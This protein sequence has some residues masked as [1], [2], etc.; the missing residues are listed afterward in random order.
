MIHNW[1]VRHRVP[2]NGLRGGVMLNGGAQR[3]RSDNAYTYAGQAEGMAREKELD[4]TDRNMDLSHRRLC[5]PVDGRSLFLVSGHVVRPQHSQQIS[6]SAWLLSASAALSAQRETR[7]DRLCFSQS[8]KPP[9]P[10][11]QDMVEMEG[12]DFKLF[13]P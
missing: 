2:V 1:D 12:S 10:S 11:L 13:L 7:G 5:V 6:P 8:R 3:H 9:R 4:G